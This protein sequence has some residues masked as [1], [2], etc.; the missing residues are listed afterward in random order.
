MCYRGNVDREIGRMPAGPPGTVDAL[1]C[2]AAVTGLSFVR[3]DY[4]GEGTL[5][6]GRTGLGHNSLSEQDSGVVEQDA[7][8]DEPRTD[9]HLP[10]V[11]HTRGKDPQQSVWIAVPS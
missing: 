2:V 6:A 3:V 11:V 5:N 1:E 8:G 4:D 7:F 9:L 10:S